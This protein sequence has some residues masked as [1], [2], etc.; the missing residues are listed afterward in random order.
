[1]IIEAIFVDHVSSERTQVMIQDGLIKE[2]GKNLGEADKSFDDSCLI[3]PGFIDLHVHAREDVSQKHNYKETFESASLAA[4]QGGVVGFAE[5]PNNPIPPVDDNSYSDKLNLI[6][7]FPILL[8]AAIGQHT[9]PLVRE[10]PYKVFMGR[11]V[12]DLFFNSYPK[13]EQTIKRYS[14]KSVSFHCE[15]PLILEKNQ[16]KI[17]HEDK[18]PAQAEIEAIQFAI[19]LTAKYNLKTKICHVSTKSGLEQCLAAKEHLDLTIEVT[20]HHLYFDTTILNNQNRKLLQVNPPI[21]S[22]KDR[23]ALINALKKGKIDYMVTDHAPHTLEDK[24]AGISGLPQLDTYGLFVSW[25]IQKHNVEPR[26]IALMCSYNPGMFINKFAGIKLGQLKEGYQ[27]R[28]SVIDFSKPT[29][30]TEEKIK[31]KSGWSP[32]K[33]VEFPGQVYVVEY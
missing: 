20:P 27:A 29:I 4:N 26:I 2:V 32:F 15:D 21:R 33:G 6:G 8:Y 9:V 11:S 13:L 1:M 5:M 22:E 18:R 28:F 10:V 30:V 19:E 25:L 3:F 17:L 7:D 24:A 23:L 12:G 31:S 14:G 16:A